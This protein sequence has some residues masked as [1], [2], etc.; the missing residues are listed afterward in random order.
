MIKL[1]KFLSIIII[2]SLIILTSCADDPDDG[3]DKLIT[4]TGEAPVITSISPAGEAIGGVSIITIT[5]T[6]FPITLDGN[7]SVSFNGVKGTIIETSATQIRVR[8]PIVISDSVKIKVQTYKSENFSNEFIYKLTPA[9]QDIYDF[10]PDNM[11]KPISVTVDAQEN[12]YVYIEG[13]G[14]FRVGIDSNF[15]APK[16]PEPLFHSMSYGPDNVIY[17]TRNARGIIKITEGTVPAVFVSYVLS[18]GESATDI[19]FDENYNI[20]TATNG[21]ILRVKLDK[22]IKRFEVE[23]NV[24]TLKVFNNNIFAAVKVDTQEVVWKIPIISADSLGTPE[25][26]F[27]FTTAL[28]KVLTI[29]DIAISLDGDIYLATAALFDPIY[30]VHPDKS[31]EILYPGVINSSISS[32][33]WGNGKYLYAVKDLQGTTINQTVI[34]LDMQKNGAPYY[35]RQ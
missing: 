31:F 13:E 30:I 7:S 34:K 5:G 23:G 32:L 8:T 16:G 28:G 22:D 4:P 10:D 20:W 24:K 26:Y 27:N 11:G 12:V 6:N 19:D 18:V 2:F 15:W 17:A 35:G 9:S 14:I 29:N 33:Y 1:Y 21:T 3:L 25:V